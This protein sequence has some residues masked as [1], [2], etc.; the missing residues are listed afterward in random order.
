MK[1]LKNKLRIGSRGSRLALAQVKEI[2]LLIAKKKIHLDYEHKILETAGDK[3]KTTPLSGNPPDDFFTNT[4]DE[5]LRKSEIDIAIH[6]AKDLPKQIR[7]G[8]EIF[9]LTE[10]I[11]ETDAFIGQTKL[12][13][14]PKGA[15]I[16]TS[17][18]IRQQAI[19]SLHPH[20]S[21][22]SIR[23][24]IEERLA[25]VDQG[26]LDGIIVATCA[27]KR[28]GLAH[29]IYEILPYETMPLQGQLAV[30]GRAGDQR[31]KEIFSA[32]DIRKKYGKVTLVGA[33]PGDPEFITVK[34]IKC[35][36]KC[37]CVFYDYLIDKSL[38][39]YAK[40]AEKIYVGKRKGANTLPQAELSKML[41]EKAMKGKSV[42][43]LK[44]GDPLIF[45]RGAD[46]IEYLRAYHIEVD[47]IPGVSSA[48]GIPAA[49][50]IPLTARGI[51]SSVAFISGHAEDEQAQL[52]KPVGIPKADT[53]VFLMGLTKLNIIVQSLLKAGWKETA[54]MIVISK[55][56]YPDEKIVCGTI[57]D[58]EARVSREHL[59][60]P[61]LMVVGETVRF[62]NKKSPGGSLL[63][64]GTNPEKYKSLGDLVHLP[65]IEIAEI[66]LQKEQRHRLIRNLEKYEIIILTSRFAVKFFFDLLAKEKFS[67]NNL[68]KID[69]AV[70]GNDTAKEL[71][72]HSIRPK[73]VADLET[74]E[75]LLQALAKQYD[76]KGKSIL[77]PRSSLPNP[78]LKD[79]LI[80]RGARV[81]ELTIYENKKPPKK[82]LSFDTINKVLFTSPSTVKNFLSD[83]GLIPKNWQIYSKGPTTRQA[84]KDAGYESE[85]LGYDAVS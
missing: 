6:S 23:G 73:V 28:L 38:L 72:G 75:G 76:L 85:V 18:T 21:T 27:L 68:R 13:N 41:R 2:S 39:D 55:G 30:V 16:G 42:V 66:K 80:K 29:R 56:T 78:Y 5:A 84:L 71:K 67:K 31:L 83:Y 9:A 45:G 61:A 54:P 64:V 52:P 3:D 46:E 74:G 19:E 22:V 50:R 8:L 69:F 20:V 47:V 32:I 63:Y 59:A 36:Q 34:A 43:R 49:L 51:S 1:Q 82:G 44:G 53:I 11:D 62:W 17:S 65:M 12:S 70:V 4:L 77:L 81:A 58:I 57:G 35:L 25:M 14:L 60:P 24:N 40:K 26:K 79:E 33:G 7:N 10:S 15:T 48:T 37:D